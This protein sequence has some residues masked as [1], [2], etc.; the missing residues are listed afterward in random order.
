MAAVP[1]DLGGARQFIANPDNAGLAT[2]VADLSAVVQGM[3][4]LFR[5]QIPDAEQALAN[6]LADNARHVEAVGDAGAAREQATRELRPM[7]RIPDAPYGAH[8]NIANIRMQN[9][10]TFN[11]LNKDPQEVVRWSTKIL[12]IAQGNTLSYAATINLLVQGSSGGAAD[13]IEQ[14]RDEGKDI[15]QII[16]NLEMRYGDLCTPQEARVKCNMMP[17]HENECLSEFIDRLR[18]M[19]RMACRMDAVDVRLANTD[20]LVEGNIRRVLPTSVRIALDER[21]LSR[22]H[23]GL[24]P[25]TARELEKECLDLEKIRGERKKKDKIKPS[26]VRQAK[27]S[28]LDSSSD[29]SSSSD[30]EQNP[31]YEGMDSLIR[32]VHNLERKYYNKGKDP[33]RKRIFRKAFQKYNQKFVPHAKRHKAGDHQAARQAAGFG[34]PGNQQARLQGPPNPLDTSVKRLVSDLLIMA[35]CARGQC[36]QCGTIGHY[37]HNEACALRD[38]VLTDRPC[39]K[40]GQGLHAADDCVK[41]YQ[42]GYK[43]GPQPADNRN[44]NPVKGDNLNEQ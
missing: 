17:R 37:M 43:T 44:V 3:M 8:N 2:A 32:V 29:D 20:I 18:W 39:S 12:S 7:T 16:Q 6:R 38:K 11:G 23:A 4:H 22:S 36:I 13:Y 31:D 40:C 27:E 5:A 30:E 21:M 42:V 9:I 35:N 33:G 34:Q 28:Q 19:V 25:L 10:T 24:P 26:F 15:A 14:M 1:P 41:V